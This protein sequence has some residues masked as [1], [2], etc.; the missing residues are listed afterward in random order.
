MAEIGKRGQVTIFVI[1]AIVV[2]AV[3]I[4]MFAFPQVNVFSSS[5]IKYKKNLTATPK[6]KN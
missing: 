3:I 4:V 6:Q 2:I 5:V 1:L